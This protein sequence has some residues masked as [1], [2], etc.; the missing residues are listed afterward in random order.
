MLYLQKTESLSRMA[1]AVA[2]HF[3]N[4]LQTVMGNLELMA[5]EGIHMDDADRIIAN[6]MT[7]VQEAAALS[8][9]MLTCLGQ[10]VG[11][12]VP[13]NLS[14]LCRQSL[15]MIEVARPAHIALQTCLPSHLPTIAAD[16]AQLQ[17][18][19]MSLLTNAWESAGD[20]NND[21]CLS[22]YRSRNI[23]FQT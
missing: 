18:V 3:N 6:A 20:Q 12:R 2:H 11:N 13:L 7:G 15:P 21:V 16:A 17:Q 10:S 19:L 4:K 1:G 9:L 14:E 23:S 22:V 5:L 8:T